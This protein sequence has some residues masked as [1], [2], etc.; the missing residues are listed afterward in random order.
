MI[1]TPRIAAELSPGG[2]DYRMFQLLQEKG[3]QIQMPTMQSMKKIKNVVE[4]VGEKGRVSSAD[5]ELLALALEL[6]QDT[7]KEVVLLTDDYAIQ[8]IASY[9]HIRVQRFAHG[10]ITKKFKWRYRCPGC[11]KQFQNH[12]KICPICGTETK[13]WISGKERLG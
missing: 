10:G 5:C 13:A 6:S 9:L 1:T 3:L 12:V 2:R 7:Q 11:G 4:E 8:N